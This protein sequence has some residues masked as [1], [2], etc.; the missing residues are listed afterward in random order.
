MAVTL[1]AEASVRLH[2][3]RG[4][5]INAVDDQGRSPLMI[6]AARGFPGVCI[7]LLEAGA[8]HTARDRNGNDA[9]AM[10]RA[11]GHTPVVALLERQLDPASRGEPAVVEPTPSNDRIELAPEPASDA[12]DFSAWDAEEETVAP[13]QRAA[14]TVEAAELQELLSAHIP[15][16]G[17]A[18]WSDVD[19]DL[20][21]DQAT[22]RRRSELSE[23]DRRALRQ[24]LQ[25]G[26]ELGRVCIEPLVEQ[27]FGS[28]DRGTLELRLRLQTVFGDLG[29]VIEDGASYPVRHA[30]MEHPGESVE[31][32]LDEAMAFLAELETGYGDPVTLFMRDMG[33]F[34]LLSKQD[35]ED[36][37]RSMENGVATAIEALAFHPPAINELLRTAAEIEAGDRPVTFMVDNEAA[38]VLEGDDNEDD[39]E[40]LLASNQVPDDD[41]DADSIPGEELPSAFGGHIAALRQLVPDLVR[42]RKI[43]VNSA[44]RLAAVLGQMRL[45]WS[46]LTYLE[47]W[48]LRESPGLNA[49]GQ[50]AYGMTRARG[51]QERMTLANL[52]LVFSIARKYS[53][54]GLPLADLIQEGNIG[55]MRAAEKFDY[56]KGFKFSTYATWWIRQA[57][58]RALADQERLIRVPVHMVESINILRRTSRE[59]DA[60]LAHQVTPDD[61][62]KALS[63]PVERVAKV[64]RAEKQVLSL[65]DHAEG[66]IDGVTIGDLIEDPHPGPDEVAMDQ[67]L[68]K[69]I[70]RLLR[71]VPPKAAQIIVLRFGLGDQRDHTLEE[72]GAKFDVTRERIRQIEAKAMRK[73]SGRWAPEILGGY[74][75]DSAPIKVRETADEDEGEPTD[76]SGEEVTSRPPAAENWAEHAMQFAAANGYEVRDERSVG[77][78]L[79]VVLESG[80]SRKRRYADK[81]LTSLGFKYVPVIGWWRS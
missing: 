2:I 28:D 81:W 58:T 70:N 1:G 43:V 69:A 54:R 52:R 7:I 66:Y 21:A 38:N 51:A 31:A 29:I 50:L 67:S 8:D 13:P 20:P 61:L 9:L 71:L 79:W 26:L 68:K 3:R 59:L 19:I 44:K 37:G 48:T 35:E 11:A 17:S 12:L 6:A 24:L 14:P 57:I 4:E 76:D 40:A 45:R 42:D 16:D 65:D 46:Y 25:E 18:D 10:A 60:R 75:P 62:A 23:D 22:R 39:P 78:G 32:V 41:S 73:L 72:V 55:L 27:V 47:T 74:G 33:R 36:I 15:F 53:R 56:R 80:R 34:E 64:L 77:K 5:D 63:W 30:V 49:T